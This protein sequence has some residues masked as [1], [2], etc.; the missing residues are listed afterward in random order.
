M[1]AGILLKNYSTYFYLACMFNVAE[2]KKTTTER[3]KIKGVKSE[4]LKKLYVS[5]TVSNVSQQYFRKYL[6]R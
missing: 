1:Y 4:A 2:S 3:Q 5:M 6:S